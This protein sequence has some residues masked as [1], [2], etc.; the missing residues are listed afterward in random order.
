[1]ESETLLTTTN[2]ESVSKRINRK[3]EQY[4]KRKEARRETRKVYKERR[5]IR[6]LQQQQHQHQQSSSSPHNV[7]NDTC[8]V[9]SNSIDTIISSSSSSSQKISS[10]K[11]LKMSESLCQ[12]KVV[13]DCSYD[14]LM[15]FKDICK[16]ASQVANCYS[17][18]RRAQH[19][20]QLYI[21]G[22]GS[23]NA[24]NI[25]TEEN[26]SSTDKSE[27]QSIRLYDRLKLS[28]CDS[29]DVNLCEDTFADIFPTDK[30]VYLCAESEYCLP[31]QFNDNSTSNLV[32]TTTI[33]T[34]TTTTNNDNNDNNIQSVNFTQND[35]YVIGGLIDHNSLKGY[36]Y[37]QALSRGYRTARLPLKESNLPIE[38]RFVLSTVHV[39]QALCPVLSGTKTWL[40]SLKCALPPRKLMCI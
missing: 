29:W 13:I 11:C 25:S 27:C 28:N 4:I 15:S 35:I 3:L 8:V 17:I 32:D 37:Q 6:R 33:T 10:Q 2:E 36:C 40:E 34:A 20:V 31:E 5:K 9:S 21:T 12:T 39:F 7:T 23:H 38:G 1:M 24:K 16:L 18:N 26:L 14:H 30:I 19:P 22:L